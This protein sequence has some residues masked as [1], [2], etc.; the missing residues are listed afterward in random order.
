MNNLVVLPILVPLLAAVILI[1]FAKNVIVQRYISALSALINIIVALILVREVSEKGIQKL[2]IGSWPA[3]FGITLV[4]DMLSA[5]LVLSTTIIGFVVILYSFKS[6]GKQREKFYYYSI[7]QFQIIG[8][9]GAFTTGDIFNMF[10]FF[11]VMLMAS[12][13]LLVI[14]GTKRQLRESLKYLTV[15]VISSAFFVIAIAM[16]YSVVGTLNMAQI[17]ERI[18]SLNEVPGIL[19]VIA[20]LFLIVFG[21]KGAI[22]PLYFWL[23]GSYAVPPIP[24]MALFGALLTK[25]GVY[26]I[27]RT[28]TLFFNF[29]QGHLY[30]MLMILAIITVIIGVIGS[31]AYWDIKQIIIYNII[32]AIGV[33]LYGVAVSTETSLTGSVFY[34]IHDMLIKAALF[35]LIGMIIHITGTSNLRKFSGLIKHYPTLAWTYFIAALSL[36]GIPPLSGFVGKMLT[37]QG[38]FEANEFIGSMIIL[39]TSILV[40]YS[41]MKIFIFGFWGKADQMYVSKENVSY[42]ALLMPIILIVVISVFYGVGAEAVHSFI[43]QAVEPLINP[44]IYIEA[45]LKE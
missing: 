33:I 20:V 32:T 18:T 23:P 27:I 42:H 26:S 10:V 25:V 31:I 5:L 24:V 16:L 4:S 11:E 45:V 1:F 29:E 15:N 30:E 36:G 44:E 34:L 12:Y 14:G 17:G 8:V 21:M 35:L 3:P 9:I 41:V 37:V 38:G 7:I 22:F 40:L 2:D 13:V 19:T 39:I 6:I 28:F 43:A